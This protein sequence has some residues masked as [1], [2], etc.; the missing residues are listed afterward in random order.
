MTASTTATD[1]DLRAALGL[2]TTDE[3]HLSFLVDRSGSI[4]HDPSYNKEQMDALLDVLCPLESTYTHVSV[5]GYTGGFT[6]ET[7]SFKHEQEKLSYKNALNWGGSGT[8]T[9]EAI[10]WHTPQ[11][12]ACQG[13][14]VMVVLTDGMPNSSAVEAISYAQESGIQVLVL[15]EPRHFGGIPEKDMENYFGENWTTINGWADSYSVMLKNLPC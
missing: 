8:P 11:L 5:D 6:L 12:R 1:T 15:V 9:A 13:T 14:K 3:L 7:A 4:T 2:N 10:E